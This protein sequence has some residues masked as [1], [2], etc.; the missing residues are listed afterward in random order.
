MSE[1][2]NIIFFASKRGNGLGGTDIYMSKKLP[3]GQWALAQNLGKTINTPYDE[4]FPHMAEDGKTLYFASQGH[5]S[6]GGFDVFKSIYDEET[7]TWSEPQNLGY[8]INTSDDNM[9]ISFTSNNR[10]AYVSALRDGGFGDL[11]IYRIRFNEEEPLISVFHGYVRSSDS[12][13]TGNIEVQ[14]TATNLSTPNETPQVF[15]PIISSGK[16]VMSLT[17]GVYSISIEGAGFAPYQE[18]LHVL[19]KGSF[20]PEIQKDFKLSKAP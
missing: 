10:C 19:E 13:Q 18:E 4:D 5:S 9:T 7:N 14:I 1:D 11:D 16:Y 12:L 3:N 2:G 15:T 6:M 17:P 8:P 20:Q